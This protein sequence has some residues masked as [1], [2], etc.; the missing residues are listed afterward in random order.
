MKFS[1]PI[2]C[3]AFCPPRPSIPSMSHLNSEPAGGAGNR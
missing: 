2:S 3:S 1:K